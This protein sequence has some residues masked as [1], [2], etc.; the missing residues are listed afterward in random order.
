MRTGTSAGSI[1]HNGQYRYT[2][3]ESEDGKPWIAGEPIGDTIEIVGDDGEDLEIGF[4]LRPGAT[5]DDAEKLAKYMN[6]W[7]ADTLLW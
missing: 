7:I 4:T 2:V 3:K 1:A 6:E 5:L